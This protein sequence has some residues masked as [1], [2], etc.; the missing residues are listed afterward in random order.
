MECVARIQGTLLK[1][2]KNVAFSPDG[3]LLA[4]SAMD[5][6]H[7]I[8]I[9]DWS[10]KLKPGQTYKPIASGKGS[11]ANILSL[12][13]NPQGNTLVATCVKEVNFFTFEGGVIKG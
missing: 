2:I 3:K 13:F 1:G 11:K 5:D 12:A 4:A 6:D 8:A 7:T 9:Y 10:A